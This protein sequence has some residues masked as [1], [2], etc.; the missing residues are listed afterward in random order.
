MPTI[1]TSE[2]RTALDDAL[3]RERETAARLDGCIERILELRRAVGARP[4]D[5]DLSVAQNSFPRGSRAHR[6]FAQVQRA[7]SELDLEFTRLRA[8]LDAAVERRVALQHARD[9]V[10]PLRRA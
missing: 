5:A 9:K 8:E 2:P 3:D 10:V 1:A 6:V 4:W 7:A